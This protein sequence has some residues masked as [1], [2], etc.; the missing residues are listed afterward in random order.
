M[1]KPP[2][3]PPHSAIDG[4]HEDRVDTVDAAI[5]AGQDGRDLARAQKESAGRPLPSKEKSRDD[6]SR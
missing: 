5:A 1:T 2:K 3:T 4:V 6:R